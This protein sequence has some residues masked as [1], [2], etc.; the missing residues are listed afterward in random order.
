[1]T[2]ISYDKK[3]LELVSKIIVENLTPDLI[4]KKWRKR[5]S[6]EPSFGHC[7]SAS[8]VLQKIF[9]T[10]NIKLY[11]A[12]DEQEIWHW[13]CVDINGKRIDLTENQYLKWDRVPP[14]EFGE[15]ASMLGWGYRKRVFDLLERVEKVLD[16]S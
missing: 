12:K 9:G 1:M 3:N 13:W 4:P 7:H 15:K 8:V 2:L 6:I 14:Y 10:E 16:I 5:N 11:R